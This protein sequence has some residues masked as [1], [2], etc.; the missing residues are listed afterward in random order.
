[1]ADKFVRVRL[2][3]IEGLDLGLFEFDLDLTLMMFF[4]NADDKIY[5]RYG[6]RDGRDA[7]NRQ[8]LA[9]LRYTMES[10]LEMHARENKVFAPRDKPSSTFAGRGGK[11]CTHC[12]NAKEREYAELQRAGKWDRSFIYRY[13][14]PDNIGM[15]L[16]VDRG[17]VVK[18][19][20]P[21][22]PAA[23]AGLQKGDMVRALAGVPIHSFGDAQWALDRARKQDTID[24]TWQRGG[25]NQLAKLALPT[26]WQKTDLDWRRSVRRW[27][28]LLHLDGKDLSA[29]EKKKLG[30]APKQLAYRPRLDLHPHV[31]RAG[32]K[33]DDI[34]LGIDD[35]A[36]E[37]DVSGFYDHVCRNYL[38]GDQVVINVLR[39]G[40]RVKVPMTLIR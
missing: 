36:L 22:S 39:A 35:K 13:P 8:S 2:P 7:D 33:N 31:K 14:I 5:A 19:V 32:V 6:G 30:L 18:S 34:I 16:E 10:V 23:K 37:T 28:P 26:G 11:G 21:D 17:N 27:V 40:E 15:I 9:G 20:K 29:D 25:D 4:L 24:I 1:V 38:V 12:H 3:R